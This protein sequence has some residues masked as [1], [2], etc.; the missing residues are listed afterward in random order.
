VNTCTYWHALRSTGIEDRIEGFG[1]L[2]VEH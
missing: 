2:L 1:S